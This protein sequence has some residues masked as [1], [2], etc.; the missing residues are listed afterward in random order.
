[1]VK[2][3]VQHPRSPSS[4]CRH[5]GDSSQDAPGPQRPR[6]RS[7]LFIPEVKAGWMPLPGRG[8]EGAGGTDQV[9]GG[10]HRAGQ[11]RGASPNQTTGRRRRAGAGRSPASPHPPCR[12]GTAQRKGRPHFTAAPLC[13]RPALP[14]CPAAAFRDIR[15]SFSALVLTPHLL[16]AELLSAPDTG[17]VSRRPAWGVPGVLSQG[18]ERDPLASQD[19]TARWQPVD[20]CLQSPAQPWR[21]RPTSAAPERGL[22]GWESS[23]SPVRCPRLPPS[24]GTELQVLPHV[25]TDGR[26]RRP[27]SL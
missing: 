3:V 4:G 14:G 18:T 21:S 20:G 12:A 23:P 1:M 2:R 26:G 9:L 24:L 22:P 8:G 19:S 7:L 13:Q 10:P 11:R 27:T 5:S 15:G 25:R 6:V 17:L 16:Y